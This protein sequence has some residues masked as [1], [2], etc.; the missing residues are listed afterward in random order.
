MTPRRKPVPDGREIQGLRTNT[1]F[2]IT[3]VI[4]SGFVAIFLMNITSFLR[5][6]NEDILNISKLTS[7]G[8][9]SEI[10]N[11]LTKPSI[12]SLTMANDSFLR[13]WLINEPSRDPLE[14]ITYLDGLRGKYDYDSSFLI[15]SRSLRY[16]HFNGIFKTISPKDAHDVWYYDFLKKGRLIDLDVDHDEAQKNI[17]T[18]FVNCKIVDQTEGLLG[19]TG[20]GIRINTLQEL[21][22]G[23]EESFSLEAFLTDDKGVVQ[24]HTD[25]SRFGEKIDSDVFELL[26]PEKGLQVYLRNLQEDEYVIGHFIEELEWYLLIRKDISTLQRDF[27]FRTYL[28]FG[29]FVMVTLLVLLIVTRLVRGFQDRM[30]RLS[31]S[32]HLTGLLNRRGFDVRLKALMDK[33]TRMPFSVFLYDI[34]HFK[35][36]NDRLGHLQ[37]DQILKRIVMFFSKQFPD[38]INARWGGDEFVGILMRDQEEAIEALESVRSSIE[39]DPLLKEY[40]A[41]VSI[42]VVGYT[43]ID[44]EDSMM[45]KAD[46]ALYT[47]KSSGRNRI[48]SI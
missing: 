18:L 6:I 36:I 10:N 19:V 8:I 5:T 35:E 47:A 2:L 43:E 7:I 30:V 42:G 24:V 37:G 31:Q 9:F 20:V 3:F 17:L 13:D 28:L 48:C 26:K 23:F 44:T 14:V 27:R 22:S 4:L 38:S 46:R 29:I 21:L 1:V 33:K 41:T 15:S 40:A 11:E 45:R 25:A 32:D 16:F 12:V 34:D 39:L